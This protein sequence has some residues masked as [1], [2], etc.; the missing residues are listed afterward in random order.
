MTH[1]IEFEDATTISR[2]PNMAKLEK[3]TAVVWWGEKGGWIASWW[4]GSYDCDDSANLMAIAEENGNEHDVK[5]CSEAEIILDAVDRV[6]RLANAASGKRRVVFA[7][8]LQW[9]VTK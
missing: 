2:G 8:D 3:G 6:K 1:E 5:A 7:N 4:C 9:A